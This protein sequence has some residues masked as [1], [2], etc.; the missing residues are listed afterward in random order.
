MEDKYI[1]IKIL[2][3]NI[4]NNPGDF[5]SQDLENWFEK[6]G[7][8]MVNKFTLNKREYYRIITPNFFADLN[9]N[10]LEETKKEL[11]DSTFLKVMN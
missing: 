3:Q 11:I 5:N 8:Q 7:N 6:Y 9:F 4:V 2:C 1:N 10:T